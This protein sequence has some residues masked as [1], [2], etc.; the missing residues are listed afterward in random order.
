LRLAL[1][2]PDWTP[3]G[4]IATYVRSVSAALAGAGHQVLVCHGHAAD[5][6]APRGVEIHRLHGYTHNASGR[7]AEAC[8][9]G[10]M[11]QLFA[12]RPDVVHIHGMNNIPLERRLLREFPAI[13]TFHVYDFCPAGT[14]FHHTTDR[15]CTFSTGAACVVRQGYLRCTLS[16]RPGVWWSQYRRATAL[17]RHN[18][19]FSR[20]IVA[21]NY[22]KAEAVRT[23]YHA[24]RVDVVP[25]FTEIPESV[26]EP[27][28]RHILFVGRL[29]REKGIDLLFDALARLTGA[30]TCT[31]VGEGIAGA[32]VREQACARGLDSRVT[33]TG[34]LNGAAL[35]TAFSEATVVAVPS[36]WPEPFGIVGLEGMS[37]ARPVVAFRVGGIPDWLD[38]GVSGCLVPAGD[39]A[40]F[41][42]R[43]SWLLDHPAEAAAMGQRGRQRVAHDFS[44]RAHLDQ[45]LPIYRH[46]HV[47][48]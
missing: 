23:G 12:F 14:K 37:H 33:F 2:T 42:E 4:G 41:A 47:P 9:A 8:V 16:K 29:V 25:Y 35:S 18:R 6:V 24:D 28:P 17:N 46:L 10:A 26:P 7:S 22:A 1:L 36:R 32:E 45:L 21:S 31:V 27:R 44:A 39:V 15:A 34:W 11:E 3:N 48:N 30:W 43:L 19:S 20:C 5:G 40:A 13:K 38:D